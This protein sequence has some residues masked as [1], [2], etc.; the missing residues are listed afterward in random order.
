[1]LACIYNRYALIRLLAGVH[2]DWV[3][4]VCIWKDG[5]L[6]TK[7]GV[8]AWMNEGQKQASNSSRCI[9]YSSESQEPP[10]AE[11]SLIVL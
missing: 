6:I 5:C 2:L 1:M 10:K 3:H 9:M 4:S 7:F 8:D 11:L